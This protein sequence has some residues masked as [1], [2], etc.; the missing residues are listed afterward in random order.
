ME[1]KKTYFNVRFSADVLREARETLIEQAN[2]DPEAEIVH[3]LRVDTD[4]G[5]WKFDKLE[6]FYSSYRQNQGGAVFDVNFRYSSCDLSV[7]VIDRADDLITIVNVSGETR[8]E[9]EAVFAVFERHVVQSKIPATTSDTQPRVFIGHGRSAIWRD[10]KD[11]LQDQHGY[12]VEAY[13]IGAR[14]GHVIR[15]ILE[16]ML[17][18]SDI[19][20]L[21][22]T[23]ED[24]TDDD[25][26]HP[27]L[28]VVHE[29]GL[30]QG[31]LGFNRAIVLMEDNVEE[32][33]NIHGIQQIRFS[34]DS[35]RE[36]YGDVLAT[37]KRE[38]GNS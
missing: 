3:R 14:A 5:E 30:F 1:K 36:T 26:L 23:G 17:S 16:G 6:E 27:R 31:R 11:H 18:A 4:D 19:A 37:L 10:L 13:E 15:D 7:M 8:S 24:R 38:F 35:I 21:V 20:I 28:N 12:S 32:F 9:I 22:M 29:L 2:P 33:S 34:A 25:R